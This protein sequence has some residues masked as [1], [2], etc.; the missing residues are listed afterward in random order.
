MAGMDT[1]KSTVAG[2][3]VGAWCQAVAGAAFVLYGLLALFAALRWFG[4]EGGKVPSEVLR[5]ADPH[6]A[7]YVTYLQVMVAVF[8]ITLG[9]GMAA[10]GLFGV[11]RGQ[12]WAWVTG[13]IG[14][15]VLVG[16]VIATQLLLPQNP[17]GDVTPLLA[18]ALL[19]AVGSVLSMRFLR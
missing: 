7:Q 14:C 10:I 12:W 6:V 1:G 19:H 3:V 5:S 13:V 18:V 2:L 17:W 8:A 4:L 16:I 11:R 15:A 9:V